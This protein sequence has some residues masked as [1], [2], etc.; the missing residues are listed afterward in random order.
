MDSSLDRSQLRSRYRI[1]GRLVMDTALHIGGGRELST[2]TDSPVVRDAAGRPF[3][4]GSSMKG[5]FRA[6]VER[7][8][9]VLRLAS[10]QLAEGS[11]NCASTDPDLRKAYEAVREQLGRRLRQ[12]QE[13][14]EA[15]ERLRRLNWVEESAR[16][17]SWRLSEDHLLDL[18]A[19]HLCQTCQTFG[20]VHLASAVLFHDL[21]LE[22]WY[23]LTQVRDGVGIDRDSERARE[24][25]KFD[26]EVVPP[27]TI[28][29]FGL[30]LENPL[31][32]DLQ[33]VC[34]GLQEFIGGM[35][36]VGGIRTRGLGQCHLEDVQVE[37]VDFRNAQALK[38]Y[39]AECKLM[40]VPADEF[41]RHHVM[42]LTG[43]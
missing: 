26:Y 27:Q 7:L 33:L 37:S 11:T 1:T 43:A 18:L 22:Q 2:I 34:V 12:N 29:H 19:E 23:G 14:R 6:A 20:S 36:P 16:D 5:A 28:F 30:T 31:P 15:M 42:A 40:P 8:A 35:V 4:P 41:V 24:Q 9:P 32:R 3:I 13:T 38:A 25:I 17:Q 39:L 21:P 10:C